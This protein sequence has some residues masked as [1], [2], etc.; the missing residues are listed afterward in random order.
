MGLGRMQGARRGGRA[1]WIIVAGL[2]ALGGIGYLAHS[3]AAVLAQRSLNVVFANADTES[4]SVWFDWNGDVIAKDVA[5]YLEG[6][7]FAAPAMVASASA[8]PVA[9]GGAGATGG[10]A[11]SLRFDR[12]RVKTPGGWMFFLRNAIDRRLDNTE[13][14]AL[15]VTFEG[16]DT[17]AGVEPTL[18]ALGPAGALSASPFEAEG[19][20]SHA[21]FVREELGAMGLDATATSLEFDLRETDSRIT[22]RIVLNSPGVSRAQYDREESLAKSTS[23]LKL[24]DTPTSTHSERWDFS[25]QGFVRARN[26]WCAKQDGVDEAT[27]VARHVAAVHRLLEA[28][29]LVPDAATAAE[30]ADFAA[31]GGQIA[32]GGTYETPLHSSERKAARLNGSA[33]LRLQGKLEHGSRGIP[34]AWRGTAPRALE[35]GGGA[36]FAAMTKENGGI[37]PALGGVSTPAPAPAVIATANVV[38]T[39]TA[40]PAPAVRLVVRQRGTAG[41]AGQ[42]PR[43]GGPAALPG[44]HHP[45]LHDA[46]RTAHGDPGV[47]QRPRS[48]GACAHGRGP[49]RLPDFA[50]GVRP[51]HA[52]PV[53]P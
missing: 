52:D 29:G 46:H 20:M 19:C 10:D 11:N 24:A 39:Q 41:G 22:T 47:G 31:K 53:T 17:R 49:R 15:R 16:F 32:F 13:V 48:P 43:V 12:M 50:R 35:T 40:A 34:V 2:A 23:L 5:L 38:A 28:R 30:Y 4:G 27:F 33:M 36:T 18:G 45:G 44:P 8:G 25:D 3:Q 37:A 1:R 7:T 51:R 14:D 42:S 9:M 21:Y 26:A 6:P